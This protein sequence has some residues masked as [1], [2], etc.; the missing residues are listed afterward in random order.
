VR[1]AVQ[2]TAEEGAGEE[3]RRRD[4]GT[5]EGAKEVAREEARG[6][7]EGTGEGAK[8]V[9][10]TAGGEAA[11]ARVIGG[12]L[13]RNGCDGKVLRC[14]AGER[15]QQSTSC[16]YNQ[17]VRSGFDPPGI[18][19]QYISVPVIQDRTAVHISPRE[20]QDLRR[21]TEVAPVKDSHTRIKPLP[22]PLSFVQ[23]PR[24][25][26]DRCRY[27][28]TETCVRWGMAVTVACCISDLD[29]ISPLSGR[30]FCF[31]EPKNKQRE[32]KTAIKT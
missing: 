28:R 4:E 15:H 2:G 3:E 24:P 32:I 8:E 19:Q 29:T 25:L 20:P 21:R 10:R 30:S 26:H 22:L 13:W 14:G 11:G 31:E 6:R 17:R 23:R 27:T 1:Y 9:A 5:G 12:V 7:D 16:L 18:L